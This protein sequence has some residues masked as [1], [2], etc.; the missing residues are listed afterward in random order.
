MCNL[1]NTFI[2][3]TD[4]DFKNQTDENHHVRQT[5]LLKIPCLNLVLAVSLYYR[6]LILQEITYC[7]WKKYLNVIILKKNHQTIYL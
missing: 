3:N 6:N 5:I 7:F 1:N 2:E 4:D